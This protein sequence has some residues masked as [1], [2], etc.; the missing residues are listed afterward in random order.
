V[1]SGCGDNA[2]PGP[3]KWTVPG[4]ANSIGETPARGD[5]ATG[6]VGAESLSAEAA[7]GHFERQGNAGAARRMLQHCFAIGQTMPVSHSDAVA[8]DGRM[9]GPIATIPAIAAEARAC[10]WRPDPQPILQEGC[11][12]NPDC[13]RFAADIPA[14]NAYGGA[15]TVMAPPSTC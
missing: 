9:A 1:Q 4:R 8:T 14:K 13:R 15:G 2:G 3:R 5:A 11:S 7:W 10:A 6:F 12:I